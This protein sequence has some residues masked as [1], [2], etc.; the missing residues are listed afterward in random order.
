[1]TATPPPAHVLASFGAKDA[2]PELVGR[3]PVW[4]C[5]E[6]ALRPAPD[7]AEASWVATT[8]SELTVPG[9][10]IGHPLRSSD[11]RWVLGG[12]VAS[13]Y[14]PG[15]PEPRYDEIVAAS[16]RL[17]EATAELR[18]P[19]FLAGRADVFAAADRMAWGEADV[20]LDQSLGGRLF[21]IM[22]G[23]RTDVALRPRVVHGDL[24]GNVLFDGDADPGIIDFTAFFRPA[25]WAA[26]VVVVDA[27]AWGGA[28]DELLRRWS[29]L[30]EW[31]QMV[32]RALL[33]RLAVHAT[34]T[35]ST[36]QSLRGLE[37]AAHLVSALV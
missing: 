1:M 20:K 25:E 19:R 22:V 21:D 17:H 24:F 31:P 14:V 37:R 11:G 6:I 26:A 33:Y 16:L 27:L 7:A 35:S 29:H 28:E 8:L 32:L 4:R 15:T 10:R 13:R 36:E 34:H 2:E 18:R 23:A 12:W 5:D 9:L 30:D 3:G